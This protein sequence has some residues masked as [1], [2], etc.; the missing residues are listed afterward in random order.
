MGL[1]STLWSDTIPHPQLKAAWLT[2]ACCNIF[3]QS[4]S[5]SAWVFLTFLI[6]SPSGWQVPSWQD[7]ASCLTSKLNCLEAA[8]KYNENQAN[9]NISQTC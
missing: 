7:A 1:C 3:L 2:L 5:T 4:V 9:I 6:L 8:T